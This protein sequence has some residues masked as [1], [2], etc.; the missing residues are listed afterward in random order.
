M[1]DSS[2][3]GVTGAADLVLSELKKTVENLRTESIK[4][5]AGKLLKYIQQF[6]SSLERI[7]TIEV[8]SYCKHVSDTTAEG[9]HALGYL[10]NRCNNES[11]GL[12]R[13]FQQILGEIVQKKPEIVEK[14]E[15]VDYK[16]LLYESNQKLP[17]ILT[18]VEEDLITEKDS[19]GI[20]AISQLQRS[21]VG[22]QVLDVEIGGEKQQITMNKAFSL[23]MATDRETRKT[24]SKSYFGSFARDKLL[25]GTTLG[26]ICSDHVNMTKRRKWP[27]YMTQSL[28]DQDVDEETITTLLKTLEDK[29]SS[30]QRYVR[31]KAKYFGYDR[32]LD[33]DL[34]AP[35]LSKNLWNKDWSS[36]KT[37]IISAY[38]AFDDEFGSYVRGLFTNRRIDSEDRPGRAGV[39]FCYPCYE[40]KTAFVFVTYNDTLNDAY[41]IAHELGHGLH[42]HY[43]INHQSILNSA[44]FSTCIAETGSLFGELLFTE[45]LLKE[46]DSDEL[47]LEVLAR[48]LDRFY[49]MTFYIGRWAFF[50]QRLYEEIE[51]G[52]ILDVDRA[53]EIWRSVRHKI[54]GDT[55]EWTENM[56]YEWA[57]VSTLFIPNFRF[58]NYSYCFAQ[59]LVFALYEKFKQRASDFKERFKILL[60]RGGSMSPKE[61]IAEMGYDITQPD[62]WTLGITRAEHFLD[63]LQKLL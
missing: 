23:L 48:V 30:V 43:M 54:Y 59:L 32:L 46:C 35:W 52:G 42:S 33:Y 47:R 34:R 27:S 31:L 4:F 61:Q 3:E 14:P 9:S 49:S 26:A 22:A 25:H 13:S 1:K 39:G 17:Y 7:G 12:R 51:N 56:D 37:S 29:T 36:M 6:E 41:I 58:Y 28:I 19:N 18:R 10:S 24:V 57:R 55:I 15:L 2:I 11:E 60:S 62:F 63:D 16:H 44:Y 40:K 38:D 8:Y 21:W 50:E 20:S 5:N 45:Q 53:C